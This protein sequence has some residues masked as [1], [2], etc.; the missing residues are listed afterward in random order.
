MTETEV[1]SSL[2]VSEDKPPFKLSNEFLETIQDHIDQG[3]QQEVLDLLSPLHAADVA[4][5]LRHTGPADRE[6]LFHLI[7]PILQ[8]DLLIEVDDDIRQELMAVLD[9]EILASLLMTLDSDDAV[10]ILGDMPDHQVEF[11]LNALPPSERAVFERAL[12]YPEQSAGRLMQRE[13]VCV[14]PFWTGAEA[15]DFMRDAP[16][17]PKTFYDVYV[18]DPRH[19]PLGRIGL[20]ELL[21]YPGETSVQEMMESTLHTISVRT[22]QEEVARTFDHYSLVSAPVVNE[23]GRIVGMITVDDVVTVIEEEAEE[24]IL[25]LA[26]VSPESHFYTAPL[27]TAYWRIRWLIITIVNTLIASFVISTFEASIQK[28]TALSF[29][30]TINAAMGGNSGMQVVTVVVRALATR[31]ILEGDAWRAVKKELQV[32]VMVGTFCALVLGIFAALWQ[33]DLKLGVVLSAALMLNMLWASAAGTLL[34]LMVHRMG[35]DPAVSAGPILTT[36][37]DVIGYS[38]FL[39]LATLFLL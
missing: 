4:D 31:D 36:T 35:M 29:L 18:V 25:K 23:S 16:G 9:E 28:V 14:P 6:K 19:R 12:T 34:P 27:S 26:K 21:R 33:S 30:M 22:D 1:V 20:S 37:T 15:L 3:N 7:K 13:I 39:G 38:L 8:A 2:S 5:I 32:G 17:L 24:D 10:R 11:L